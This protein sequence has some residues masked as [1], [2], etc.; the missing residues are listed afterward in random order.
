MLAISIT[1]LESRE[2]IEKKKTKRKKDGK[3]TRNLEI[4]TRKKFLSVDETS[5]ATF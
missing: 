3:W 2:R 1:Q 5:M 4:R